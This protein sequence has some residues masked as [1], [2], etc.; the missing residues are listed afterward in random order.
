[1]TPSES[2]TLAAYFFV[3]I[4]LAIYGWHRYYLVYLYMTNRDKE[5]KPGPPLDPLP[6]VTIQ[7]PLYNEMYVTDRLVEAV[8]RID[9]PHD[10]LEIQVLD[11]STDETRS[12][13]EMA[14]RRFATEGIDIKYYHR[15]DRTGYKAGAL[16]AG[17]KTARGEF[18]AIFDADFIPTSDFLTRLM[19]HFRDPHIGMVQA[20]WGHINQDYSLLTKIQSI[21]LDGHFVLEHGGR[22]R[23]GRF[24]NFN[25]TAGVWRRV[26][27]DEAGGWQHD[28]LTE[29]LDLSYRAQLLGWKFVFVSDVIAPAEVPVEMNAFKSQQHR[30][31]KGSIQTC[32][33]LLPR[34]LRAKLPLSVKAEAFF[35]LTANFNYPFMCLLSILMF[36]AMVIR[37]NMG[38]YEMMLIDVPLFFAAT[39]SVCNFYMVCQREIHRDWRTRIKYLPFLMSIGIGLSINNTRAVFEALLNKQS[40][41]TRTPKYRIEGDSDD[42]MGK[43]YH[44]SVAVQP[45]VELA[46]GLYFTWTVFYALANQIYG[47]VPFLLLFQIGFLYTGLVSLVQQ[48]ATDSEVVAAGLQPGRQGS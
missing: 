22:N 21:L 32:R 20:R 30:W 11:D 39:F 40:E 7:L 35:H 24:F 9:Y 48:H 4:V 18:I 28:T 25:G 2:I 19:P 17:L 34:L 5:P 27:I 43:K 16:E 6:V 47:T 42:W 33:K 36:P 37:Y 38:W 26:A 8:C 41:F 10:R 13:A 31:A 29:D 12:I 23:S 14:V 1:M 45:L 15:T 3:L 44:Q 46:L